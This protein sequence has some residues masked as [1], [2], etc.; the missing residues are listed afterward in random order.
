MTN[1]TNSFMGYNREKEI[2][3]QSV[4]MI[5]PIMQTIN[6]KVSEPEADDESFSSIMNFLSEQR[7][8]QIYVDSWLEAGSNFNTWRKKYSELANRV[9]QYVG[10][11][12]NYLEAG[13]DGRA[14]LVNRITSKSIA[15]LNSAADVYAISSF[16]KIIRSPLFNTIGKCERCST[17]FLNT[18]GHINKKYC[19]RSCATRNTALKSVRARRQEEQEEKIKK[20][21]AAIQEFKQRKPK[22]S[23]WKLW[24]A[25]RAGVTIK[26]ITQAFNRGDLRDAKSLVG[27]K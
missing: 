17:Y 7:A 6:S 4:A 21:R 19:S 5:K 25:E 20:V 27:R 3:K 15:G 11:Y 13:N 14:I 8:L 24:V 12:E 18:S 9:K 26:W 1:L 2:R 23:H 16:L 22:N 10:G